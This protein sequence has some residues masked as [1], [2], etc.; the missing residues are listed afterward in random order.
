MNAVY[1]EGGSVSR[2][3]WSEFRAVAESAT[4]RRGSSRAQRGICGMSGTGQWMSAPTAFVGSLTHRRSLAALGM[5]V[6]VVGCQAT[7]RM[8]WVRM[9]R[10][11]ARRRRSNPA[12]L[13][14]RASAHSP[15][16]GQPAAGAGTP[17]A[18]PPG[19]FGGCPRSS[20]CCLP[21]RAKA[22][23]YGVCGSTRRAGVK[24]VW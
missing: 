4:R 15:G 18:S 12:G 23:A 1:T 24:V 17:S 19:P 6:R 9:A 13:G 21:L 10:M 22:G 16:D 11:R 5:T 2:P 7:L 14:G 8:P 3:K 20:G